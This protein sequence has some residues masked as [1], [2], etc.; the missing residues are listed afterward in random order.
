LPLPDKPSIAVL[1]FTSIGGDAKQERLADGITEDVI[2]DLSRYHDLFVIARN[3]VFTYK[4]KAV[5]VPE[6]GRE[7]GVRYVLEG[8]IQ[9]SGD[10]VR[11]TAQLIEAA[12][13]AHVASEQYDRPLQEFFDLQSEVTQKIAVGGNTGFLAATDAASTRRK[14][15]AS[16]QAYDYYVLGQE[17]H[18]RLTRED[19]PKSE[20]LF[21][22]AIELDP[23]FA[24]AYAG[25]GE[26]YDAAAWAGWGEPTALFEKGKALL[27]KAVALDR[28]MPTPIGPGPTGR[29]ATLSN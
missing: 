7:L 27:S 13:N 18:Y 10:R 22:K 17:L 24:R 15:P 11:V 28:P 21:K 9:T 23:Q 25:P 6:V 12:T 4:G 20:E 19:Y 2:T 8:S 16:L 3:S 5:K 26:L 1:P 29:S 14:P